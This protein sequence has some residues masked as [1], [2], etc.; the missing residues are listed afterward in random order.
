VE[1]YERNIKVKR[2]LTTI[3]TDNDG[4]D[5]TIAYLN[6]EDLFLPILLKQSIKDLG[7][8]TD[9]KPLDEI[10]DLGGFWNT[11]NDGYSDFGTNPISSGVTTDYD[12]DTTNSQ[13]GG[14]F[15]I[16][17][18]MDINAQNYSPT[19]TIPC[20]DCCD[21]GF[22]GNSSS[23]A[24]GTSGSATGG[25]ASGCYKIKTGWIDKG[26]TP[27]TINYLKLLAESMCDGSLTNCGGTGT[28]DFPYNDGTNPNEKPNGC[29]NNSGCDGDISCPPVGTHHL[30]TDGECVGYGSGVCFSTPYPYIEYVGTSLTYLGCDCNNDCSPQQIFSNI[31]ITSYEVGTGTN[32][33]LYRWGFS[34]WCLPD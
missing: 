9:I 34:F 8:Y 32:D 18:C 29:F 19:A 2:I 13:S 17:G 33:G 7:V 26:P 14:T 28:D 22:E 4:V 15:T 31:Q 3:D 21:Y 24:G 20:G 10:I 23:S 11:N 25:E 1:K 27:T 12:N 6:Q 5:D 16:T 30:L